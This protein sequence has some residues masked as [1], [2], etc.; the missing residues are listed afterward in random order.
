M[1]IELVGHDLR[2][3]FRQMKR[4]PVFTAVALAA[5]ALGIGANSAIFSFFDAIY[6]RTSA[7]ADAGRLVALHRV[8]DRAPE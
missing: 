7:A 6:L 2:F 5:V 3:A 4:S 8:D 1:R